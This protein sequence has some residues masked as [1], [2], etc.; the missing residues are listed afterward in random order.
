V[1][2]DLDVDVVFFED[3]VAWPDLRRVFG[4]LFECYD[5]R[6]TPLDVHHFRGLPRVR[7]LMQADR[8]DPDMEGPD[9]ALRT[10]DPPPGLART[11]V[12]LRDR[13]EG[14]VTDDIPAP[15]TSRRTPSGLGVG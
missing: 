6:R 5:Q 8:A 9:A 3:G 14:D 1:L 10:E 2:R 13:G 4:V 15:G 7:V 11:L 12:I